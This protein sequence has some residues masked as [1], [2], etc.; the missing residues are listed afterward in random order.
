M[1]TLLATLVLFAALGT[2][3]AP[4][5]ER[6]VI[7]GRDAAIWNV[8]GTA[9]VERA[10][11]TDVIVFVERGGDDA[12]DLEIAT[13]A[14]RGRASLRV[15]Y[16]GR[17][18]IYPELGRGSRTTLTVARDGTFGG[19]TVGFG[20]TNRQ[21]TVTG[22]GS[23]LEA[24]ANLRVQVPVGGR[25]DLYLGA[26]PITASNV[27]GD[28]RLDGGS[29]TVSATGCRGDL[30]VDTGSGAVTVHDQ[31][32][33]LS[34]DTGSGD[35]RIERMKGPRLHV[36]TGSGS[37]LA[38]AIDAGSLHV[39]TGSG[40]VR[41]DGTTADDVHV[42]TG[43]GSVTLNLRSLAPNVV[44]DTGSGAVDLGVS[45]EFSAR[46]QVDTGSGRITSD[47]PVTVQ[48]RERDELRGRIGDGRGSVRVD[49]G[50]GDVHVRRLDAR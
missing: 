27:A 33:P 38:A 39:D 37:L 10:S 18:V 45:P 8:A 11:G 4:A 24:H 1:K 48:T 40:D 50:S 15:I 29:S 9:S 22:S 41:V 28:L 44:V 6:F 14:A 21:V 2:G 19:R 36:D 26:G 16:P 3:S 43:S 35:V 5:T 46:L 17:R 31:D 20:L 34:V 7:P 47:L 25:V 13:G 23:G 32:G 30:L 49:T 12:A 42:D